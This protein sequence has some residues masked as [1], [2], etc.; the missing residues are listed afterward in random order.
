[1]FLIFCY[2]QNIKT[3]ID[4]DDMVSLS[5]FETDSISEKLSKERFN[6]FNLNTINFK[7]NRECIPYLINN[8]GEKIFIHD[9]CIEDTLKILFKV[10]VQFEHTLLDT[11]KSNSVESVN[12]IDITIRSVNSS[13]IMATLS[14]VV[15]IKSPY[16]QYIWDL[17]SAKL[18]FWYKFQPYEGLPKGETIKNDDRV[19][20]G[21]NL[22]LVP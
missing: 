20:M 1:M 10:A 17:I 15:A 7:S 8:G 18:S 9:S 14:N 5:D 11:S 6:C 13:K 4:D 22:Y 12:V 19:Y 3:Y 21:G 2:S 16:E